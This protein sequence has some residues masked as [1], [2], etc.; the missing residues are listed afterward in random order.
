MPSA[1]GIVELGAL[2]PVRRGGIGKSWL[3]LLLPGGFEGGDDAAHKGMRH[4]ISR[5]ACDQV[6]DVPYIQRVNHAGHGDRWPLRL[7]AGDVLAFVGTKRARIN[8][9]NGTSNNKDGGESNMQR[10]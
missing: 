9:Q 10:L 8:V 5:G 3:S 6:P 4:S 1:H 7:A 2:I